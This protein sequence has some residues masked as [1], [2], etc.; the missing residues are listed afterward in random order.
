[1]STKY[2]T[3]TDYASTA[4]ALE[5]LANLAETMD[6]HDF[7]NEG[8]FQAVGVAYST[9]ELYELAAQNLRGALPSCKIEAEKPSRPTNKADDDDIDDL[10]FSSP[11]LDEEDCLPPIVLQERPVRV[12]DDGTTIPAGK[13][14]YL[15]AKR[16]DARPFL[17]NVC[18]CAAARIRKDHAMDIR[19]ERMPRRLREFQ[20]ELHL[21]QKETSLFFANYLLLRRTL[22]TPGNQPYR[23]LSTNDKVDLLAQY[24][25]WDIQEVHALIGP[26]STL[27]RFVAINCDLEI[28]PRIL[29]FLDGATKAPLRSSFYEKSTEK[30]IPW[31]DF[32]KLAEVHG[33]TL[34]KLIRPRT[35]IL[36]Y[37][38]PGTGKT[39]FARA[40][41]QELGRDCYF[42]AQ[43][44]DRGAH[45]HGEDTSS[46][47]FRF[48]A[49]TLC[50]GRVDPNRSLIVV[51]EAD[52]MLGVRGAADGSS[53]KGRLNSLLDAV[54]C[55]VIWISNT[56]A[57]MLDPSSRRRFTYSVCFKPV[58]TDRRATIWR[59]C[60]RQ[61]ALEDLLPQDVT[62]AF[63]KK[64][65][66]GPGG[67]AMVVSTLKRTAPATAEEAASLAES[68]LV[69][70]CELMELPAKVKTE[71]SPSAPSR[72]YSL[73]G[74]SIDSS[75]P[76]PDILQ[77]GRNFLKTQK[78]DPDRPRMN[79]L[80]SGP[81]GTGKTEFVKY[82]AA[83]LGRP[84]VT[85]SASDLL[86]KY[87]G[88]TEHRIRE[89]FENAAR[90][91]SVLFFD[92]I[93]GLLQSR[94]RSEKS[95]EV[96]QVN[97]I[98]LRMESFGGIF[99]ASTNYSNRLDRAAARRF[100]YKVRFD[101]LGNEGKR[102]FFERMFQQP[103]TKEE[104]ERLDGIAQLTPGDFRTVRQSLY[105]LGKAV[106]NAKRLDCLE[107]ESRAKR[108][109]S[110]KPRKIVGF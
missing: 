100:T 45:M 79:L 16:G 104:G 89:A 92:E 6:I 49:L 31:E 65:P 99:I 58:N 42:I 82:Y 68:L 101:Y 33:E 91:E 59:E 35:S 22:E 107:D 21:T 110:G 80:L 12:V 17:H 93:D 103:L 86:D 95:W 1:M 83:Q 62:D 98:L 20:R 48:G 26:D 13:F 90:N 57:F 105:Y 64:F 61:E 36:L 46:P 102:L 50:D 52:A 32:G 9:Q 97:E 51:D 94:E 2:K 108:E 34:K 73:E 69:Q 37:G 53:R 56:P 8:L 88:E 5:L 47:D 15:L 74:L 72:D 14:L 71:N 24:F 27:G 18:L 43:G 25:N 40:L 78:D 44:R 19:R 85:L 41:A 28:S 38:T 10:F 66:T 7:S 81:P 55:P 67:I 30:T 23:R 70:H 11:C 109:S 77:A 84:L 96:S 87:I 3:Q 4:F 39:S 63:A 75:L 60:L 76:L 106:D 29:G 54:E